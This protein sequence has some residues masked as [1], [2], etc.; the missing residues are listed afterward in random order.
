MKS[1][2]STWWSACAR[3]AEIGNID[4]K[5]AGLCPAFLCA[6]S[7]IRVADQSIFSSA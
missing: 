7:A 1:A 5:N 3:S 6:A 4:H 2:A